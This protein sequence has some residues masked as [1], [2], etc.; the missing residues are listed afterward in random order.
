LECGP[1]I[2]EEL[3]F[4]DPEYVDERHDWNAS[5][6]FTKA[7]SKHQAHRFRISS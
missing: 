5:A 6:E 2:I 4:R 1:S 3:G 7:A